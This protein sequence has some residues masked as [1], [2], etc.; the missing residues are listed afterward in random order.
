MNSH[1]SEQGSEASESSSYASEQS[2]EYMM[3]AV[4]SVSRRCVVATA[5]RDKGERDLLV[6]GFVSPRWVAAGPKPNLSLHPL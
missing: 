4:T 5:G 6:G 3:E 2:S 1:V